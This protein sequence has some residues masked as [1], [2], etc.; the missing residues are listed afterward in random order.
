MGND[1][2][3]EAARFYFEAGV[4]DLVQADPAR[5]ARVGEE[6]GMSFEH[7]Q[8]PQDP[9][10]K[11]HSLEA[12]KGAMEACDDCLLKQTATNLVFAD[13][14]PK[15][16]LMLVGE[17]PGRDEDMQ[18]LPFV[19]RAGRLLNEM[20][21]S[22]GLDRSHV[23]ITNILPWRPPGNR[24]PTTEE[25]ALYEPFVRRHISLVNPRLLVC[26]GSIAAKRLLPID[27]SQ[28]ILKARGHWLPFTLE[29]GTLIEALPMFHPAYLLRQP[30]QKRLAWLDLLMIKQKMEH[31]CAP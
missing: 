15:A 2:L 10:D 6:S 28:G 9:L 14:N 8:K 3:E 31:L 23:Y 29:S 30:T 16:S 24:T 11:V 4:H 19:G 13:G 20:L 17:A 26:L 7:V 21:A 22:I 12:L 5:W 27:K 25:Q 1:T 18:G